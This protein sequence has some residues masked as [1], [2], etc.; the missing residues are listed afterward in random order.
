MD[1]KG[2]KVYIQRRTRITFR[3]EIKWDVGTH[4]RHSLREWMSERDTNK[5]VSKFLNS[6]ILHA[7]T[8]IKVFEFLCS[9]LWIIQVN[10]FENFERSFIIF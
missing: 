9:L 4:N 1:K 6:C 10:I 3:K 2:T 5:N 8:N 7:Q